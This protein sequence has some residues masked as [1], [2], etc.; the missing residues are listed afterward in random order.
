MSLG[1]A[2]LTLI[3]VFAILCATIVAVFWVLARDTK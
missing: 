1:V 2:G 3:V